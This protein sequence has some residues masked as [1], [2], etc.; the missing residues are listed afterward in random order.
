MIADPVKSLL[1]VSF[2]LVFFGCLLAAFPLWLLVRSVKRGVLNGR[3]VDVH[4]SKR[5]SAFWF[6]I[7]MYA[8]SAAIILIGPIY[9]VW[10]ALTG[11]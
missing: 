11:D 9:L 10:M 4:R 1:L 5:P 6:G 2:A 3:G 7:V 8:A